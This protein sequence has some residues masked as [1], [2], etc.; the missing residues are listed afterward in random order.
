MSNP[1]N[2]T[3]QKIRAVGLEC[4]FSTHTINLADETAD[5]LFVKESVHLSDRTTRSRL[6]M[7]PNVERDFYITRPGYRNHKDKKEYEYVTRL[8][9]N[10]CTQRQLPTRIARALGVGYNNLNLRHLARSPYLYGT[11]IS[12][13]ALEK[14]KYQT[15]WPECVSENTLAVIDIETNVLDGSG[16]ILCISLTM[17]SKCVLVVTRKFLGTTNNPEEKIQAAFTKYLGHY[18]QSR[19]I[20]LEIAIV[21]TPGLAVKKIMDYAHDWKPDWLVAW[22]I[23]FDLKEMFTALEREHMSVADVFCDPSV[24]PEYRVADYIEGPKQKK[25]ASDRYMSL[26]PW[27]RWHTFKVPSCS[28]W[29][30][31][32]STYAFIRKAEG[33][34]SSY[35]LDAILHKVLG[36]RK[37]KFDVA[38]GYTKLEWHQFMQANYKVEYLIYNLFDC[39]GVELLDEKTS[40]LR[41]TLP[42][43]IG[44]SDYSNFNS[45]PRQLADD[46]HFA[47][48]AEEQPGIIASTSDQMF[49][50][51][52]EITVSMDGWIITLATHCNVDNGLKIIEEFPDLS[53]LIYGWVAD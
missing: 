47:Y 18:Q 50:E 28:Y 10:T 19:N 37:L 34:E 15:K 49:D 25:T 43:L 27:E 4:K 35:G 12:I 13:T 40:D 51:L 41:I 14:H 2:T 6:V 33:Q 21:D 52:D 45:T 9:K 29:I 3:T 24:P 53:T 48:Q 26:N 39:I 31:A 30:C 7:K 5:A 16:D 8:Q 1:T 32:M 22:N 38:D 42:E 17:R 23:N 20:N 44:V 11:D 36:E 46:L